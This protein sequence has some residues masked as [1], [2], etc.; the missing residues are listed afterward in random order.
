MPRRV[1]AFA[2]S[3]GAALV[4]LAALPGA[5]NAAAAKTGL[6][7]YQTYGTQQ[8]AVRGP[9]GPVWQIESAS[10]VWPQAGAKESK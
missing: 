5:A 4:T 9:G 10:P 6:S 1:L 2:M 8:G 7:F 3:A